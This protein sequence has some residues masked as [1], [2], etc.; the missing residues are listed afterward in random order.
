MAMHRST[1]ADCL[2]VYPASQVNFVCTELHDVT[3]SLVSVSELGSLK[4]DEIYMKK[5]QLSLT[6]I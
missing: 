6:A 4:L 3:G 1:Q 2:R 5:L